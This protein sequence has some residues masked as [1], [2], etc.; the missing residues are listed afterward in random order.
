MYVTQNIIFRLWMFPKPYLVC[1]SSLPLHIPFNPLPTI[2]LS[3]RNLMPNGFNA[4]WCKRSSPRI[5]TKGQ[6][7]ISLVSFKTFPLH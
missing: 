3:L 5:Y 6:H 7:D 1:E 2:F 4:P